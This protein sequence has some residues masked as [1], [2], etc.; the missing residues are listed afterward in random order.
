MPAKTEDTAGEIVIALDQVCVD[1]QART[2]AVG[3][4]DRW[5]DEAI[6][7]GRRALRIGV[8]GAHD[9]QA[10]AIGC[11]GWVRTLIEQDAVVLDVAVVAEPDVSETAA[12]TGAQVAAHPVVV[13]LVEVRTIA[14]AGT[15][16]PRRCRREQLVAGGG[17][18]RD[19]VVVHVHVHVEA[20]RQLGVGRAPGLARTRNRDGAPSLS[21]RGREFTLTDVDPAG[22]RSGVVRDPVVGDLQIMP[23]A[24]HEDATA[25]LRAVLDGQRIDARWIAVEVTR[26]RIRPRIVAAE[27]GGVARGSGQQQ[28][29]RREHAR[30]S[31]RTSENIGGT[32]RNS[33]ALRQHGDGGP[34]QGAHQAGLLQQL[35]QIAVQRGIPADD[36]FQGKSIDLRIRI[37]GGPRHIVAQ[38]GRSPGEVCRRPA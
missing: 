29:A 35:R 32:V 36:G 15:A 1:D 34:F 18:L 30:G 33:H 11:D 4:P 12:V 38:S 23:P 28:G 37:R 10:A 21:V 16:R 3:R 27:T 2:G 9:E 31:R 14:Q 19:R 5:V 13:E 6:L 17:V 22:H 20:E 7:V 26:E 24:V 8:R 25:A